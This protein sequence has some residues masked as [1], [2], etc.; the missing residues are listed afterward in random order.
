M[1]DARDEAPALLERARQAEEQGRT[2]EALDAYQ[3]A[4]E[5]SGGDPALAGDLG[6]VALRLGLHDI[7]EQLLRLYLT[8]APDSVDGRAYLAHAL[9]EQHRHDEAIALLRQ[10][11]EARPTDPGLWT[12]LGVVRVR[13]GEPESA[14]VF[15][16]EALRLQPR[17]GRALY[18]RA[19]AR[20]DLGDHA[21][22]C[23]DYEATRGA[24]GL[25]TI[26]RVRI[27]LAE[28]LSRLGLGQFEAGWR[29]YNA[30]LS[31]A[32]AKPQRFEVPGQPYDFARGT[33]GL[34]GRSL[35]LVAEQG[36]GD[37]VMFAG[38]IPD[39]IRALGPEGR[40]T[41]AVEPRLVALFARF[42]PG[43]RGGRPQDAPGGR[44]GRAHGSGRK[45]S[46]DVLGAVRGPGA[47]PQA[48]RRR[49]PRVRRLP[50]ARPRAGG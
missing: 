5:A 16:D 8:A 45:V 4:F 44:D 39:V 48:D 2:A 12:D 32:S 1:N 49:L 40:L 15:L 20:A 18:Y 37:E 7:A 14:L 42:V 34:E 24:A 33:A 35:L 50:A 22:A 38:L 26:D 46:G 21:G 36:L 25:D 41:L 23:A 9:R 17:Y 27:D 47:G 13:Q 43:R 30:R 29:L 31:P 28:A 6:R 19:H 11:I 10:A 3:R